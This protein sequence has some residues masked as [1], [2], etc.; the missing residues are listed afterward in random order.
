MSAKRNEETSEQASVTRLGVTVRSADKGYGGLS[1]STWRVVVP[2]R[3]TH[4]LIVYEPQVKPFR[5]LIE[6]QDQTG[7]RWRAALDLLLDAG[8]EGRH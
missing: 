8:R 4:A 7:E 6:Q 3:E 1:G 5:T 2:N